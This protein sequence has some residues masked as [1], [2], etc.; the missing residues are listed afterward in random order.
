M[1]DNV[2]KVL[3]TAR[4][5]AAD[6]PA[7]ALHAIE[8]LFG[9]AEPEV[10]A[11]AELLAGIANHNA[12]KHDEALPHLERAISTAIEAGNLA[13][14]AEASL[15]LGKCLRTL[16]DFDSAQQRIGEAQSMAER[17]NNDELTVD[18]LNLLASIID[19]KGEHQRALD[20]LNR[21][22]RKVLTA[23][24]GDELLAKIH[25]NIG[26]V[27]RTLGNHSEALEHLKDA[28]DRF[29]AAAVNTRASTSNLIGLGNLYVRIGKTDEAKKFFEE[30]REAAA[31][32]G[33]DLVVAAALN[34]LAGI[35][36]EIPEVSRAENLYK[37]ALDMSVQGGSPRYQADN[38]DGL[39][40]V[41]LARNDLQ[42][43]GDVLN[44]ALQLSRQLGYR[45]GQLDAGLGLAT[46]QLGTGQTAQA[47]ET[48]KESAALAD[49]AG[50]RE[51]L[52]RAHEKLSHALE[53]IGDFEGALTHARRF[54]EEEN[55]LYNE[56][57]EEHTRQLTVKFEL[58]RSRHQADMYRMQTQYLQEANEDAEAK[59][60]ARTREL[61]EAQ[62]EI[63]TRLAVAAEYRDD[64]TGAHTRR[65][66]RNAAA[67]GF[68]MGFPERDLEVL[69]TAARLHDVGKIG[70]PDT[71]L[72]KSGRL[73][74]DEMELMRQHTEIGARILSAG[75]SK[76]LHLTE[77]ISLWH[78]ERFDG[79]GYPH[80]LE[81][82]DIPVAARIVA[83]SDVLDALTHA[84]PYKPAWPVSEA[85]AEIA[86]QRG[87]QFDPDAVTACLAVFSGPGALSP[88]DD[89][90]DWPTLL[91]ELQELGEE[92][93]F[94]AVKRSSVW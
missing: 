83:V 76:L 27:H 68:A 87:R 48:L 56:Q 73:E 42:S 85:L 24:L 77:T 72:H 81:G 43:A 36:L 61:E 5:Q 15:A 41:Y 63:V 28:Y 21:A 69:F 59:V 94:P 51:H 55:I 31:A 89:P 38:L 70:I 9:H 78:H 14:A 30:A 60:L 82:E 19:A 75:G 37:E 10:R 80:G 8:P 52:I 92:R 84:R 93:G 6:R 54:H 88:T 67:I 50:D 29:K 13:L 86:S 35:A 71:I 22:R 23:D 64:A 18:A 45:E 20:M 47:I 11:Q 53:S 7:Q 62:I 44:Q 39:G 49:E 3:E 16:G 32:S 4:D 66:G 40:R 79:R 33:D 74:P 1:M 91:K 17:A 46:A 34:N 2:S 25:T 90:P 57:S 65:V 58:E 12:G 26:G